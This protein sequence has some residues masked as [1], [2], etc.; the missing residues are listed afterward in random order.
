MLTWLNRDHA[1]RRARGGH[2]KCRKI[3]QFTDKRFQP[4]HDFIIDVEFGA[5]MVTI[6]GRPFLFSIW[7]RRGKRMWVLM[8]ETESKIWRMAS[9]EG[10]QNRKK[11]GH[12]DPSRPGPFETGRVRSGSS[13]QICN[14]RPVFFL[15]G[16]GLVPPNLGPTRPVPTPT[17]CSRALPCP[18]ILCGHS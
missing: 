8:S 7:K 18:P 17:P 15:S 14:N 2:Q 6:D 10:D 16:S 5:R 1:N 4:V 12:V 11:K 3:L 13:N 9:P